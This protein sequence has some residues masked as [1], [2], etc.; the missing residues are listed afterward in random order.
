M[1][2]FKSYFLKVLIERGFVHQMSDAEA[3]Y[4][5]AAGGKLIAYV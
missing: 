2:K 5:L 3:L 4:E 1:P